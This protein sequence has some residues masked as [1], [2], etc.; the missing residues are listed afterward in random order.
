MSRYLARLKTLLHEKPIPEKLTKLTKG[1]SVSFVSDPGSPFCADEDADAIEERAAM[2]ADC[3]PGWY[4]KDWAR[5]Q[6]QRPSD[7][8]EEAWRRAIDDGGRFLD[9][10]GGEA[11]DTGWTPGELFDAMAG[12][13]WRL[14][15]ERVEA[16]SADHIRLSYGRTILRTQIRGRK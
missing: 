15:G 5:F 2:A 11:A 3:V 10:W 1:A 14:A 7:A 13:V 9:A 16:V 8:P 4:L 12:L 6:Y